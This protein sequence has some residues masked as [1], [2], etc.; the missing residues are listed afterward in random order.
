[1][2]AMAMCSHPA[3]LIADEPTT[4]LDVTVQREILSLMR[5]L[6]AE[7]GTAMIFITT[8]LRWRRKWLMIYWSFRPVR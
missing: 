8:T 3:L 6:Q 5:S 2:I 4:A 7:I 1:M